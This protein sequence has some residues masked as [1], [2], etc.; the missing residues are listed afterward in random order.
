MAPT[1]SSC[2][3]SLGCSVPVPLNLL[4]LTASASLAPAT[5]LS[6]SGVAAAVGMTLHLEYLGVSQTGSFMCGRPSVAGILAVHTGPVPPQF[7][8]RRDV[9]AL[10]AVVHF[11]PCG[12]LTTVR[13]MTM[14]G[15]HVGLGGG[16]L[17]LDRPVHHRACGRQPGWLMNSAHCAFRYSSS[18]NSS[19]LVKA[20]NSSL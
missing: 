7:S 13:P 14:A 8:Q 9:P 18:K 19:L 1:S 10:H 16:E 20:W 6:L 15:T 4:H 12:C 3:Q 2:D 11:P 5:S 17:Q